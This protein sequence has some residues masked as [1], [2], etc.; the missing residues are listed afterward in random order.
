VPQGIYGDKDCVT[1][2]YGSG[3]LAMKSLDAVC[4]ADQV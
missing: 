2:R 1:W 4:F 3:L